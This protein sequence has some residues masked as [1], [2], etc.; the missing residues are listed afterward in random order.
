M[1]SAKKKLNWLI[2]QHWGETTRLTITPDLADAMLSLN[3]DNRP[4]R[5]VTI[6]KYAELMQAGKWVWIPQPISFS[7]QYRL[8]DGQHRLHACVRAGV[9]VD[10]NVA[11]GVPNEV[12][13]LLDTGKIR[14]PYDIFS[15]YGVKNANQVVGAVR[16][17]LA[18]DNGALDLANFRYTTLTPQEQ[19][20]TYQKY[21]DLQ[22]S[23]PYGDAVNKAKLG[24]AAMFTAAHYI[25]ARRSRQDA[26]DFYRSLADGLFQSKT[27]PAYRLERYLRANKMKRPDEQDSYRRIFAYIIKAWNS[28]RSG[29][30][31]KQFKWGQDETFPKAL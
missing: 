30:D 10:A 5:Q 2:E 27:S 23:C 19:Y 12:F 22:L 16:W 21:D 28:Y 18:Y 14:T 25:C 4:R 26:N 11:F 17:V 6:R 9:P 13:S 29:K 7:D 20:D 1:A 24:S 3:E 15:I 31:I 8:I